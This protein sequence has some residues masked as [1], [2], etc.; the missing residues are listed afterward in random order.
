MKLTSPFA[1]KVGD[2]IQTTKGV[3]V[4]TQ[5][6]NAPTS[7]GGAI[8]SRHG[9]SDPLVGDRYFLM[10]RREDGT[11]TGISGRWD[12]EGGFHVLATL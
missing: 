8:L 1:V 7:I 11:E 9:Q 3:A 4:I 12:G 5:A 2:R 6:R 10:M